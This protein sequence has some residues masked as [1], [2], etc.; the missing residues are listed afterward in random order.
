MQARLAAAL[1]RG[2]SP[3]QET[4]N[5]QQMLGETANITGHL[6]EAEAAFTEAQAMI[7]RQPDAGQGGLPLILASLG[8]VQDKLGRVDAAGQTLTRAR[9]LAERVGDPYSLYIVSYRLSGYQRRNGMLRD[10]L[11]TAAA[12]DAWGRTA[13][14]DFGTL[15]FSLAGQHAQVLVAYG[16][17][18]RALGVID[19]VRAR[20]PEVPPGL[21]A[22]ILAVR[23]EALV[24]LGRGTEAE[25]DLQRAGELVTGAA[26]AREV[27]DTVRRAR[28][29]YWQ[30]TG[31]AGRALD[32][33]RDAG[34]AAPGAASAPSTLAS[35][36]D[37]AEAARLLWA[38]GQA[39]EAQAVAARV[40]S[41][42]GPLPERRYAWQAEAEAAEVMGRAALAAG[43]AA[44][45]APHLAQAVALRDAGEDPQKSPMLAEALLAR[46]ACHRA[47]GNP[48]A[49]SADT[50]RAARMRSAASSR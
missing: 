39:D 8:E 28:R 27:V 11:S 20:L 46:A 26:M 1:A 10:A 25:A 7:A 23:A 50:A 21:Q 17:L 43:H 15:P 41:S 18:A 3:T 29:H 24:G 22:P 13:G 9:A 48:V 19:S 36:R 37:Q 6:D 44:A 5:T 38:A 42:L 31:Q 47:M 14:P 12:G 30:A 49:A 33:L 45:A 16:D 2:K 35:L 34:A 32:D 40:L 4:I